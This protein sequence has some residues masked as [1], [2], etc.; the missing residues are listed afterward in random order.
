MPKLFIQQPIA[1]T[2]PSTQV[3]ALDG[4][5]LSSGWTKGSKDKVCSV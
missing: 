2:V 4:V 5:F 1:N 3:L